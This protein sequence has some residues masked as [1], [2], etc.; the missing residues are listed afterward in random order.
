LMLCSAIAP[1][2]VTPSMCT[3]FCGIPAN[4][5]ISHSADLCGIAPNAG[6]ALTTVAG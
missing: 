1:P 4:N 3:L 5:P 2:V 6:L